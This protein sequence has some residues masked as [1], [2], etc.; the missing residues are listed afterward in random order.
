MKIDFYYGE[1]AWDDN[2]VEETGKVDLSGWVTYYDNQL[3][4]N[5]FKLVGYSLKRK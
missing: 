4:K 2:T 5:G 3:K 1:G